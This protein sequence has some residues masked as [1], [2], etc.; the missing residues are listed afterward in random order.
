MQLI[1]KA[2]FLL[3]MTNNSSMTTV[4]IKDKSPTDKKL[5]NDLQYY[6][7]VDNL[8]EQNKTPE[9]Y[10]TGDEFVR[11]CKSFVT[12]YYIKNGLL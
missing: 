5:I 7:R 8:V 2:T 6:G 12:E 10:L 9:G 1:S 11:E 3:Q 4:K